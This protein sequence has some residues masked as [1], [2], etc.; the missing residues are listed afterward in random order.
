MTD[1]IHKSYSNGTEVDLYIKTPGA[2]W[3]KILAIVA[4]I[5]LGL[6]AMSQS[7]AQIAAA[8]TA[9]IHPPQVSTPWWHYVGYGVIILAGVM[10]IAIGA[11]SLW[12]SLKGRKQVSSTEKKTYTVPVQKPAEQPASPQK[13]EVAAR[14]INMQRRSA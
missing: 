2:D 9:I 3:G 8:P 14:I 1:H 13:H 5:I 11:I 7:Q 6:W 12:A 4:F 10:F